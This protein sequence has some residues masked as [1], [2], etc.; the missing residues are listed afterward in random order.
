[1]SQNNAL[2]RILGPKKH[3]VIGQY[4]VSFSEQ[5]RRFIEVTHEFVRVYRMMAGEPV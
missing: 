3:D 5:H 2:G 1:M 4:R